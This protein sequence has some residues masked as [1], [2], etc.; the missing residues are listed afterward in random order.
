L[1]HSNSICKAKRKLRHSLSLIFRWSRTETRVCWEENF[2]HDLQSG[3]WQWED[4]P[5]ET[6]TRARELSHRHGPAL[7]CGTSDA[8]HVASALALA[9]DDFCTFD[10]DQAELARAVGLRV[11]G[12]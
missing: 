11:L 6:W 1:P 10:R 7:G 12:S 2:E 9:A 5:P 4:F 8:L 3:V